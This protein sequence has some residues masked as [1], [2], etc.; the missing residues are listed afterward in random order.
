MKMKKLVMVLLA[1][2]VAGVAL[3]AKMSLSEARAQISACIAKPAKMSEIIKQLSA[4]DQVAFLAAVNEAISAMPGS[5]EVKAATYLNVDRAAV[6]AADA[7]NKAAMIAEV[8]AT[9]P[10]A[11][12]TLVNERFASDLLNIDADPSHKVTAEQFT[13]TALNIMEKVNA[14]CASAENGAVRSTFAIIMLIRASNGSIPGLTETLVKTLPATAQNAARTEWIPGAMGEK[15]TKTY[16]PL[17]G[18]TDDVSDMSANQ[19]V[20]H[21]VG[22]QLLESML[23]DIIEGTPLINNSNMPEIHSVG[24]LEGEVKTQPP[25]DPTDPKQE[26]DGYQGQL[27]GG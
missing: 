16:E 6:V 27:I 5:D 11:A 23:G 1:A 22:P 12:L 3:A 10:P 24:V 14:R 20:I 17:L 15:Q 9:V 4:Q 18:T 7:S 8:F 2:F 21:L 13:R 19:A 26:P 25:K